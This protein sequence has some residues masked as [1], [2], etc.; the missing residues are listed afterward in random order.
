MQYPELRWL[1]RFDILVAVAAGLGM[2]GLGALLECTSPGL[3]TTAGRC[4]CGASSSRPCVCYHATYTINSLSHVFGQ[5]RYRTGDTS[6]NNWWLALS[7]WAKAG[8]TTTTTT[9]NSARQGFYW[10]EIDISYY[11]L[12]VLSWLGIIWDLKPVPVAIRDHSTPTAAA[13]ENRTALGRVS[14]LARRHRHRRPDRG[15]AL[16]RR[17]DVTVFEAEDYRRPHAHR[18]RRRR[19]RELAVDTGFIVCNDR[20]YP[21]FIALIERLGVAWQPS[22]MSFSL[23]RAH[24]P[25]YNGTSLNTL[26]AQ[27]RNSTPSF[28]A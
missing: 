14:R 15:A 13:T 8:T 9:R 26:F 10:W 27:R 19:G 22:N 1:D 11:M 7:R 6:R 3:G 20:T 18:R 16:A 21:R 24:R 4:W 17:H 23:R 5:Q 25:E 2:F 28:L 12:K